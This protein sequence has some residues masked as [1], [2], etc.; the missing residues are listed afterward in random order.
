MVTTTVSLYKRVPRQKMCYFPDFEHVF[1][2]WIGH[3]GFNF[4]TPRKKR[5]LLVLIFVQPSCAKNS[6]FNSGA[7]LLREN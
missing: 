5:I 7:P 6:E 2:H 1:A 3:M 4:R